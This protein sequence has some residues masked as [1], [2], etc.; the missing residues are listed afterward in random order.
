MR[1]LFI[2]PPGDKES[3][4]LNIGI[5][6]CATSSVK[7]GHTVGILDMVNIRQPDPFVRIKRA[8]ESFRPDVIGISVSNMSFNSSRSCSNELKRYFKGNI[9]LGGPEVTALGIRSLS[10]IPAADM[11]VIGEGE[12]TTPELLNAMEQSTPLSDVKGVIWRHD[13]RIVENHT[14]E[15]IGDLD[16]VDIPNYSLFGVDRMDVY[17]IIT[18][19]GCPYGCSFC[20]SAHMGKKW[21]AR[22]PENIIAE[23][24][25]AKHRYGAKIFQVCDASFN[26][27][28][29]RVEKFC[30]LLVSEKIDMPWFIQGFRADRITE[31]M[32]RSLAEA[33]CKR[34]YVGVETLEE[35][36]FKNVNKGES[37]DQIRRGI[38]L[39]KKY[40]IEIFGY[41]LMGLPGDT[42]KKT[43]RSFD[44]ARKLNLDALAYA[45]CVPFTNTK[46]EEWTREHANILMDSYSASS[47]GTQYGNIAFETKDFTREERI[48]ARRILNIKSGGYNEPGMNRLIFTLKKWLLIF[49][50]DFWYLFGRLKR[51][52]AYRKNYR[53]SIDSV[54]L[55]RGIYFTRLPDGT[56]SVSKDE[57]FELSKS[58][59]FFLDLK[60]LAISEVKI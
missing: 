45:S 15:F 60:R 34:I 7:N 31:D 16:E 46:I 41:M 59:R 6:Y 32:M 18:S 54:N 30:K 40:K 55:K 14:R 56:W 39:M 58:R 36:V 11:A 2:D 35:D 21:R 13:D 38:E 10:L 51:S 3:S 8:V 47:L 50:Y 42:F 9:V 52:I 28:I 27:D 43:L 49:R 44:K 37:L 5:A 12:R 23:L 20:F 29:G 33:N 57:I 24:K 1:M 17:I 22:S 4:G 48:K 26:V 19:R 53:A 25:I